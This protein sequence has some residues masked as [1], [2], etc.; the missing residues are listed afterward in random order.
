MT[1]ATQG[2]TF[3]PRSFARRT[4]L[5][6]LTGSDPTIAEGDGAP[7]SGTPAPSGTRA[8]HLFQEALVVAQRELAVDLAH[9]LEGD[10]NGDQQV[11]AGEAEGLI[12]AA[13]VTTYGI[14]AHDG[15]DHARAG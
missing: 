15:D 6:W 14:V 1:I 11:G 13:Q 3:R 4:H 8:S 10:A 12:P 9:H 2:I 7:P 5:R